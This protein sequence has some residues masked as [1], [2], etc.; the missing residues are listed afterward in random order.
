LIPVDA[1]EPDP[2]KT[3]SKL[4]AAMAC[5]AAIALLAAWTLDGNPR[6]FV[7]AVLVYFAA[8]TYLHE[9]RKP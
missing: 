8:R 7:W 6:L 2:K 4:Y 3:R 9:I 1:P 5:Y